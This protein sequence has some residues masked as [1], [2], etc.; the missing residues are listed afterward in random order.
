MNRAAIAALLAALACL[1]GG[2]VAAVALETN[3]QDPSV[4]VITE[5][6]NTGGPFASVVDSV[7]CDLQTAGGRAF[8]VIRPQEDASAVVAVQ[9]PENGK[10]ERLRTHRGWALR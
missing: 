10:M 1:A 7:R 9:N 5:R 8:L 2:A 3:D 6:P 4:C